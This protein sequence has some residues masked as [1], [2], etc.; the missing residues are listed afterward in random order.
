MGVAVIKSAFTLS[1]F[2]RA[3]KF[4]RVC[5]CARRVGVGVWWFSHCPH[6]IAS[7]PPTRQSLRAD[8]SLSSEPTLN[9]KQTPAVTAAEAPGGDASVIFFS[10]LKGK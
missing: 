5:V 4:K 2:A 1:T 9:A 8:S 6:C 7:P 10:L 3:S